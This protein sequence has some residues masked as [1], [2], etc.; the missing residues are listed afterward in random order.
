MMLSYRQPTYHVPHTSTCIIHTKG[1][2]CDGD[3]ISITSPIFTSINYVSG[4]INTSETFNVKVRIM[5]KSTVTNDKPD[6][7]FLGTLVCDD[8][9]PTSMYVR[10]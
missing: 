2:I 9:D 6:G 10:I 4:A 5:S 1:D 7:S 3:L 8:D